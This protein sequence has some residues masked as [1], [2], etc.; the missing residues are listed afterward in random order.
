VE[1]VPLHIEHEL[2]TTEAFG[3]GVRIPLRF[4]VDGEGAAGAALL[5]L[6]TSSEDGEHR[7]RTHRRQQELTP[8]HTDGARVARREVSGAPGDFA[9]ESAGGFGDVLAVRAGAQLDGQTR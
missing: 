4:G 3:G 2:V 5:V 8:R 9:G 1:E 6:R 7:C